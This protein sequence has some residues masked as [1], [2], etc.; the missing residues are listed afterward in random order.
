MTFPTS[1]KWPQEE[2][3]GQQRKAEIVGWPDPTRPLAPQAEPEPGLPPSGF[4]SR[5]RALGPGIVTGA[6]DVDPSMVLTATVAG[7]AYGYSLLWVVP[8]CVPFLIE[9]FSATARIGH[10]SR[11]GL[12]NLLRRHYGYKLALACAGIIIAIN[13]A[14][15]VADLLAVSDALSII[16]GQPRVFFV[17]AV[18][19]SIWYILIFRDYLKITRALVWLSLPL[20]AYVVAAALA[21][22]PPGQLLLHT[23]IPHI[24]HDPGYAT[25]IVALFGSLLTPYVLVWQTGS[26]R[27]QSLM[28]RHAPQQSEHHTGTL[29]TS[30]LSYSVLIAAAT[31]LNPNNRALPVSGVGQ[32]SFHQAALALSPLGKIGPILFA[33]GII[34]AG[35]VALPVLVA[36]LC[37]AVAEAMGWKSG[38]SEHPWDAKRFYFLI[39][40]VVFVAAAANF[41]RINAVT[42]LYWSQILAGVLTVPILIFILLLANNR[43]IMKVTN[44]R[45]Q[46]FWIG[47]AVGALVAAGAVLL[48]W[49]MQA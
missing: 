44:T 14:M 5:L 22:P 34:G 26:R 42:A 12:V 17:A 29:V 37:Y 39:S 40:V 48:F 31:V 28:G 30:V 41:F 9:V 21:E 3:P 18:A 13:M 4:W 32:M 35:M 16:L 45:W 7:A 23:L 2:S 38:L 11:R 15:I 43:S 8:L 6:S 1:P 19:F 24:S 10:Q 49:K 20:F 36:S 25:A 46:N 33:V 47:A 27:E